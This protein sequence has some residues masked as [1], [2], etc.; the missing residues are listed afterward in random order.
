MTP[1]ASPAP[2]PSECLRRLLSG[3]RGVG[4]ALAGLAVLSGPA[5]AVILL[6]PVGSPRQI[7]LQVGSTNATVNQV[8]FNVT[9]ANVAPSPTP[10]TGV[11]SADTPAT[12]PTGGTLVRVRTRNTATATRLT[13]T[14]NSSA[15]LTC[16]AGSGCGATVIP[17]NT[18]SWTSYGSAAPYATLDIQSGTFTGAA[19][20]QLTSYTMTNT[21]VDMSNTLIFRYNNATLYPAGQYRGRVV[22]TATM[23]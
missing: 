10:V 22:Y 13:L 16:V 1:P 15:G 7:I 11:P 20:Q 12:T 2:M 6:A 23:P 4:L 8:V 17:F 21:S 5:S 9:G 19:S 14:V 18:I 3:R